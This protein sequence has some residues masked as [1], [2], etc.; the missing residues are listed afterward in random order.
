MSEHSWL[1]NRNA[2]YFWYYLPSNIVPDNAIESDA[3]DNIG[4]AVWIF[5]IGQVERKIVWTTKIAPGY[6]KWL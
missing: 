6:Q 4:I 2:C 3:V 5:N 1:S